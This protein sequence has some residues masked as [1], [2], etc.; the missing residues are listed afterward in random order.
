MNKEKVL[1]WFWSYRGDEALFVG[2]EDVGATLL[3][4]LRE[5]ESSIEGGNRK[6]VLHYEQKLWRPISLA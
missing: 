2:W 1:I 4:P 3:S 5:E 6:I